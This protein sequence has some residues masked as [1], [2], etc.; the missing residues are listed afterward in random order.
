MN[1]TTFI[2]QFEASIDG[3]EPGS[4]SAD[5]VLASIPQWDSLA[6]LITLAMADAEYGVTLSGNEI[7]ACV[8]MQNLFDLVKSKKV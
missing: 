1:I 8:T 2:Q 4:V 3:I 5:T 6:L 7:N